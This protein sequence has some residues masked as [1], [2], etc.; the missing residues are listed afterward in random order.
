MLTEIK[1][2]NLINL[3]LTIKNKDQPS[4]LIFY[5]NLTQKYYYKELFV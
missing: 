3:T 2:F 1:A 5:R 4:T